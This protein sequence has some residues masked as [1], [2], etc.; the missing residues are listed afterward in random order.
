MYNH[1]INLQIVFFRIAK[2]KDYYNIY[3]Y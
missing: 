2:K 1:H 3:T